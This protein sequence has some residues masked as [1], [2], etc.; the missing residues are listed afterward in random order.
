MDKTCRDCQYVTDSG[1]CEKRV[2]KFS[3]KGQHQEAIM[4]ADSTKCGVKMKEYFNADPFIKH[5]IELAE[6]M[7][8]HDGDCFECGEINWE[9]DCNDCFLTDICE[10][11]ITK[12]RLIKAQ[13]YLKQHKPKEN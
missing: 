6:F 4:E 5:N 9:F 2:I 7:L 8:K 10:G 11:L 3:I 1:Y 12:T 13:E